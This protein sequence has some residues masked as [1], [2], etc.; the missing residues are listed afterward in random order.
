MQATLSAPPAVTHTYAGF[1]K[2][3]LAFLIDKLI[4]GAV[5]GVFAIPVIA[6]GIAGAANPP[7]NPDDTSVLAAML[8]GMVLLLALV[9]LVIAWLYYAFMESSARQ[10]T[11]GKLAL[12]IVV[13]DMQGNKVSFG[14][15]TGRYFGKILSGLVFGIGF[16]MAGFSQQKQ[17]LHDIL[18]QCLV[19]NRS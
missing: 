17:A 12:G 6:V 10:G 18:S 15:A 14:R 3:F 4:L 11:L 9:S 8:I 7:D 19:L 5:T 1:W 2:R 13:T 16:L